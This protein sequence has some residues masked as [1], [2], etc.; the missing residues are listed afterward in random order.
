MVTIVPHDSAIALLM[1][2]R[3]GLQFIYLPLKS[4]NLRVQLRV[5]D[6]PGCSVYSGPH[7]SSSRNCRVLYPATDVQIDENLATECAEAARRA[8]QLD[9]RRESE[10]VRGSSDQRAVCF[11]S[12]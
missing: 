4:M 11:R 9:E 3:K 7:D 2:R 10:R 12:E 1:I 6:R 5:C 8:A